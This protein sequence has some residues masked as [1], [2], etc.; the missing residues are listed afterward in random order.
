[1]EKFIKKLKK[2]RRMTKP[3][4]EDYCQIH[5]DIGTYLERLEAGS[6]NDKRDE[7]IKKEI[8]D[9]E[10]R[11]NTIIQIREKKWEAFERE[12]KELGV[13]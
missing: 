7:Q 8:N 5:S 11:L 12:K 9:L 13:K 3:W 6:F 4:I 1:M 10:G 2:L